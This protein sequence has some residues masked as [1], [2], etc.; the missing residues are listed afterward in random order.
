MK[1]HWNDFP[2]GLGTGPP[3]SPPPFRPSGS[4]LPARLPPL[5]LQSVPQLP[6]PAQRC[7]R[8]VG[9][10]PQATDLWPYSLPRNAPS[11]QRRQ[12]PPPYLS[13]PVSG[14]PEAREAFPRPPSRLFYVPR[15][16]LVFFQGSKTGL[17]GS[18]AENDRYCWPMPLA[19]SRLVWGPTLIFLPRIQNCLEK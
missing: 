11:T 9:L 3:A 19:L 1:P 14:T 2:P 10:S 12:I 17:R 8:M 15:M 18:P 16:R 13:R 5:S 7:R 6:G 4:A